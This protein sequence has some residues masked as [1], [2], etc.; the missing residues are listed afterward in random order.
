[1][2]KITALGMVC[3]VALLAGCSDP[4]AANEDNFKKALNTHYEKN[5]VAL[6]WMDFSNSHPG[7]PVSIK[8]ETPTMFRGPEGT[9]EANEKKLAPYEALVSAGLLKGEDGQVKSDG[10][11]ADS[12]DAP[13]P[14]RIYSLTV[15]GKK[16]YQSPG[17][18]F[19]AGHY[20][21]ENIERFTPPSDS[22]MGKLSSVVY[23]YGP[24]GEIADWA[25]NPAIQKTFPD[26]AAKLT[27]HQHGHEELLLT[28]KGWM[29]ARD[30]Q[31]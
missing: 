17:N 9:A 22:P 28:N 14:G 13:A 7:Y 4:K 1:M 31:K 30:F 2:K 10:L 12:K 27:P 23:T 8:L 3:T 29:P 18:T 21:V 5:C 15:E 19:C 26:F 6:S 24:D 16:A 20:T 25:K 11:F